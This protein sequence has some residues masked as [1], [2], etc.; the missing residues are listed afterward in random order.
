[1]SHVVVLKTAFKSRSAMKAAAARLAAKGVRLELAAEGSQIERELY[2]RKVAGIAAISLKGWNYPVMVQ[3]DGTCQ[4]DNYNGHWGKQSELDEYSQ[5]YGRCLAEE[6]LF[7]SGWRVQDE[8]V[9]QDGT[10]EL[11]FVR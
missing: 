1:M 8:V 2:E 6:E 7:N 11:A 4:M 9:E 3:A 10:L 5:Q